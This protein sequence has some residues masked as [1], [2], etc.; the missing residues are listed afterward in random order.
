M[1][2]LEF[3]S[4]SKYP[5]VIFDL[6]NTLYDECSYL[7]PVY[8]AIAQFTSQQSNDDIR[9]YLHFLV[10]MF[11]E[12]G[13]TKLFDKYLRFFN[14]D[15]IIKMDDL[16]EI[17][18]NIRIPLVIFD[19][20]KLLLRYLVANHNKVYILTNGNPHQQKNKIKN[21]NI[22]DMFPQIS[23]IYANEY[24]PKPSPVCLNNIIKKEKVTK[25]KAIFIGDS[26][27]DKATAEN[28]RISFININKIINHDFTRY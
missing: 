28:A 10:N 24:I 7:L 5:V 22:Q 6:D 23:V 26:V 19:E 12:E 17:Q 18:R 25:E 3:K 4:V 21:L 9:V 13:R 8:R 15:T 20:V 11:K 16:L 27:V 1:D 14:L 2:I